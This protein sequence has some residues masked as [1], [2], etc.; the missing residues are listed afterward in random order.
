VDGIGA[1]HGVLSFD[2]FHIKVNS[3]KKQI[4]WTC[5]YTPYKDKLATIN[6]LLK[7]I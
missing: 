7:W 2:T 4:G 6:K 1:Y 3:K 5:R